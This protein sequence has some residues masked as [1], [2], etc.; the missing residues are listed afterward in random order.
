MANDNE[1]LTFRIRAI[2]ENLGVFRQAAKAT[3]EVNDSTAKSSKLADD[4]TKKNQK[5]TNSVRGLSD[6]QKKA[7]RLAEALT[8]SNRKL[9]AARDK[10]QDALG[11]VRVAEAR[12]D[13]I[14]NNT[15][16]KTAQIA[17]GEERL[18]T[19]RR[20]A[21]RAATDAEKVE[22][23]FRKLSERALENNSS[24]SGRQSGKSWLGGFLNI[25]KSNE[26]A[27]NFEKSGMLVGRTFGSG[28]GSGLESALKTEAGPAIL[29][30]LIAVVGIVSPAIGAVL[31][32]GVVTAFGG[33]LAAL[34]IV[35]AAKADAVK[36]KWQDTMAQL[37]ADMKLLATPFQNTLIHIADVFRSTVDR[38]NPDLRTAFADLAGP[39]SRFADD[40]GH[41][42]DE[43]APAVLPL[44]HAFDGVLKALGPGLVGAIHS[45]SQ[46]LIELSDSVGRNPTGLADFVQ[47]VGDLTRELLEIIG[48]LNT[49]NGAFER[50]SGGTSLVTVFMQGLISAVDA[51]ATPL[52]IL[53]NNITFVSDAINALTHSNKANGMSMSDAA[54]HTV[55]LVQGMKQAQGAAHGLVPPLKDTHDIAVE[56]AKAADAAAQKYEK[57]ITD[58]FAARDAAVGLAHANLGVKDAFARATQSIKDNGKGINTNTAAGRANYSALLDA[59]DAAKEQTAQMLRNKASLGAVALQS[60]KTKANFI[61]LA[62]QMTGNKA[63]AKKLADQLIAI[64]NVSRRAILVAQKTDLDRK[65]AA[66]KHELA[67]PNLTKVRR[68]QI[69]ANIAQLQSK[70]KQAQKQINSL[71]G[72]TVPITYTMSGVNFT[73]NTKTPSRVG[74]LAGGGQ[75]SGPGSGTSDTAGVFALSNKEYVVKAASAQGYGPRAMDSVNKGTATIIPGMASGGQIDIHGTGV[76]KNAAQLRKVLGDRF[77]AFSTAGAGAGVQKWRGV[78]L[79]ALAAA[80]EPAAWINSLLAR[81][82]RESGGNPRAINLWD[83]NAKRGTPSI[84]LMQTI[85]PTFNAY[86]GAYRGRGIYDPFANIYAAIRYTVARYGSGPAGWG[87]PGGYKNGGWLMPGQLAYNETRKPEAVFNQQQLGGLGAPVVL[88]FRSDGSPYMEFLIREFRKYVRSKGGNVQTVLGATRG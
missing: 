81:M 69:Q 68:A 22:N 48:I 45:I 30:G 19:A 77:P 49:A 33:G 27:N 78:A 26:A 64:P 39:I 51:V 6:E 88:E 66:A 5:L 37:G 15:K 62:T 24:D 83:S 28:I 31:A 32:S 7:A 57:W 9:T 42:F 25:F 87:R 34:G 61:K 20:N 54:N 35:F 11:K 71:K 67:D 36:V 14:R 4:L 74:G 60:E 46:G 55:Q 17:A 47:G 85:G 53:A 50:L 84:G 12:L 73:L 80:H 86:A 70:L 40:V 63:T 23:E 58:M 52:I 1:S 76:F 38:F 72:K 82:Q 56:N 75:V 21:A 44:E 41:A 65:L 3:D 18:A 2:A 13:D 79:A 10:E 29:A 8:N 43:F 16:A 59:A